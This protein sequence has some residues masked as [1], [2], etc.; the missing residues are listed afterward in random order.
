MTDDLDAGLL[1]RAV[2]LA[3]AMIDLLPDEQRKPG[4]R[5]DLVYVLCAMVQCPVERERLARDVEKQ[6]G[7]LIDITDWKNRDWRL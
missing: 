2:M 1:S 6:T 4:E 5:D 7:Q 3:L